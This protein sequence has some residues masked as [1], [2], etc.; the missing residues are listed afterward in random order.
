MTCSAVMCEHP[1]LNQSVE[2]SLNVLDYEE[3]A[4]VGT[5]VSFHCSQPEE[6]LIGSNTAI[7]MEDGEWVPNPNQLQMKCNGISI[8]ACYLVA[9]TIN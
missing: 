7:C 9:I 1:L 3:P 2:S 4:I 6:V 5:T 8:G